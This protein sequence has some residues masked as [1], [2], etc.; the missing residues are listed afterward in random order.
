MAVRDDSSEMS[1]CAAGLTAEE[2]HRQLVAF[3]RQTDRFRRCERHLLLRMNA[4]PDRGGPPTSVGRRLPASRAGTRRM[5]VKRSL[6][7]G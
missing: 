7:Q 1:V 6:H 3:A 5:P 4:R 2:L